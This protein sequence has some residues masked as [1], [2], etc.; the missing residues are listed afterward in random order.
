MQEYIYLVRA[1]KFR[2][3]LFLTMYTCTYYMPEGKKY[4]FYENFFVRTIWRIPR[5]DCCLF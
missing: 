2:K 3:L 5:I 4:Y 1:Q